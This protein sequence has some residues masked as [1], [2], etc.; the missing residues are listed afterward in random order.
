MTLTL[1]PLL[2]APLMVQLHAVFGI[3][4]LALGGVRL[5]CPC[6]DGVDTGLGWGFLL[7]LLLTAGSG[8]L[9]PMP[10]GCPNL[11]GVTPM[12]GFAMF[13]VLGAAGAVLAAR[14]NDRLRWRKIVT[15]AFAGVLVM[16]GLFEIV[17]GRLLNS[18]LAGG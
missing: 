2:A 18:V 4:A 9:I 3:A 1:A 17:P 15:G 6:S 13:A 10:D 14:R 5:V 8:V 11:F 16:A 7:F 12:H